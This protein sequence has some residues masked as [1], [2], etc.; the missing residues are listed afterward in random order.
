MVNVYNNLTYLNSPICFQIYKYIN[1][2]SNK[3]EK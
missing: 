1:D 2:F 3:F